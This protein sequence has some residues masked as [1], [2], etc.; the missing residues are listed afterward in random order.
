MED[1]Y[2]SFLSSSKFCHFQQSEEWA[3]VKS[4]WK[5]EF[6]TVRGPEGELRG[7]ASV[8][9]RRI[10]FFGNMMYVPRGPVCDVYDADTLEKLTGEIKALGDKYDAF[11]VRMEPCVRVGDERFSGIA[12]KLG[13]EI[14]SSALTYDE[15]IQ[16]RHNYE[17]FIDGRTKEEVF[18]SFGK[19]TRYNIRLAMRHGVEVRRLGLSDLGLFCELMEE[20]ARRDGF[21]PRSREYFERL[22]TRMGSH[23]ELY[24]AFYEDSI[25][26]AAL[27]ITYGNKAW[28]LYG[29]SGGQH[30]NTMANYLL[31]W[32]MIE[33]AVDRGLEVYSFGGSPGRIGADNG[34]YRFKTGFGTQLVEYIGEVYIPFKPVKFK[35]YHVAERNFRRIR[36]K[37]YRQKNRIGGRAGAHEEEPPAGPE[38]S[39]ARA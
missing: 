15:E 17:L 6:I 23:A 12:K 31:Q 28:Y 26:S 29:A 10:P 1:K 11:V 24:G 14:N 16:A 13:Y 30:R 21:I 27:I 25:V 2:T 39:P 34:L 20:T 32:R 38:P 19:K 35:L 22:M 36:R 5:S 4:N 37:L 8:L 3:A 18:A 9:I 7:A 33:N